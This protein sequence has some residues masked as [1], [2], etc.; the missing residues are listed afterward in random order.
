MDKIAY[1]FGHILSGKDATENVPFPIPDPLREGEKGVAESNQIHQL[2]I[3]F[4][5]TKLVEHIFLDQ[6]F[7]SDFLSSL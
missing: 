3:Y 6:E 7:S 1:A 4:L 5:G 2:R